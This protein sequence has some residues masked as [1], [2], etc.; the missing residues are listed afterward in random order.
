MKLSKTG[1]I[2]LVVGAIVIS[3]LSLGWTYSQETDQQNQLAKNLAL[4]KQRLALINFDDLNT[5][6]AQAL[7]QIEELNSQLATVKTNLSSNKDSIDATNV[8]LE[9][10][11]SHNLNI[12]QMLSTGQ[13]TEDVAGTKC[14]SL[15]IALK[16]EGNIQNIADFAVSLKQ[17]FPTSV[18]KLVQMQRLPPPPTPTPTD[19]STLTPV[20]DL[21]QPPP[22]F[23]PISGS[24]KDFSASLNVVIYNYKGE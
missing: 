1:W 20:P 9:N 12:T 14:E 19:T 2:S 3:A 22:G 17:N 21:P 24:E 23:A 5:Q 7:K 4:S 13:G 16:V 11:K 10:A 8:I 6:K 18:E 15:A